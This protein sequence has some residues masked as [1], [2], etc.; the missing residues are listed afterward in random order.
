[1]QVVLHH[2]R[3]GVV[4]LNVLAGALETDPRTAGIPVVF[5]RTLAE[6]QAAVD[7]EPSLV[8]W[9]CYS[10]DFPAVAALRAQV[11]GGLHVIGGV[12]VTARPADGIAAGFDWVAVGEGESTFVELVHAIETGADVK[13]VPGL[14]WKGGRS[15]PAPRF[16]LDTFPPFSLRHQRFNPIEITRGCVYACSF[17]QTPFVFKARFRHRSVDDVARHVRDGK[18]AYVRF[19]TPTSL[20]YGSQDTTPRL[21]RVE[22][23]LTAVRAAIGAGKIY[24][25]S[26]PSEVRP[27]HVTPEAMRLLARF[28]DN[29]TLI[30]GGQSG[31]ERV[32]EATRRGHDV[33]AIVRAV[34]VARAHGFQPDVDFLFGLPGETLDDRRRSIDL[35]ERLVS[36]G[37]RI[38]SHAFLPLPGT[39]LKDAD[40][41][42]IEP[43][44]SAALM[45]LES[46]GASYGQ[47]RAQA[48]WSG[49]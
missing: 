1:M 9:S 42:P 36:M 44:I 40:A 30:I 37:A 10:T 47:W 17:C 45:R 19:V 3:S 18:L 6:V 8:A 48:E 22:A 16:A 49:A 32:L 29:K 5:A 38:H 28:V 2:A 4:A 43:E 26:F 15:G 41:V 24:F 14:V 35:A 7:T 11:R 25:G 33:G 27:E 21:D 46:R 34:E 12:H 31:S 13:Q 20:S 39:P 23:L